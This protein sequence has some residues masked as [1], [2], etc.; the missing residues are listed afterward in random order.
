MVGNLIL[1]GNRRR[2]LFMQAALTEQQLHAAVLE[3]FRDHQIPKNV[4]ARSASLS[5]QTIYNWLAD[6]GLHTPGL[7]AEPSEIPE[8]G[9][10]A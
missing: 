6:A 2:E 8:E 5:R 7:E 4:I 1:L 10:D 9:A 3:A